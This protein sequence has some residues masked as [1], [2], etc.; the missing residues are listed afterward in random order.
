MR[1]AQSKED[2]V[3]YLIVG[4]KTIY[5]CLHKYRNRYQ[6]EAREQ[7]NEEFQHPMAY[8]QYD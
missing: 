7:L 1:S 4:Y 5:I 6:N 3:K 8:R 2:I